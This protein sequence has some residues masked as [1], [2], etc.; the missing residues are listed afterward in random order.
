MV[1]SQT[2]PEI[3][4][5]FRLDRHE[6]QVE[7]LGFGHTFGRRDSLSGKHCAELRRVGSDGGKRVVAI[8]RLVVGYTFVGNYARPPGFRVAQAGKSWYVITPAGN[9]AGP[10]SGAIWSELDACDAAR[11]EAA[12]LQARFK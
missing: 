7:R 1:V 2:E 9:V 11:A 4:D 6:W 3:G 5:R 10:P 12:L 8:S